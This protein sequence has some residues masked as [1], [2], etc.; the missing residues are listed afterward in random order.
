MKLKVSDTRIREEIE[1]DEK[2]K[3][4]DRDLNNKILAQLVKLNRNLDII[5]QLLKNNRSGKNE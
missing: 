1:K 2:L 4:F 3:A 5:N